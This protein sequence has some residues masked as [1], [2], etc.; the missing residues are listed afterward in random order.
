MS[1][2]VPLLFAA[3]LPAFVVFLGQAGRGDQALWV[4]VSIVPILW[5]A[6]NF[7]SLFQNKQ[8]QREMLGKLMADRTDP[9]I[10]RYFVG[11]AWPKRRMAIHTHEDVGFLL[12]Y[13]ETLEYFGDQQRFVIE[14]SSIRRIG[15]GANMN[16][17]L[18]LGRWILIEA[19]LDSKRTRLQV[20]PRER[21]T[22]FGNLI[23]GNRMAAE[24]RGWVVSGR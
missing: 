4:W 23:L 8:M 9:P 2:L 6:I 5:L 13:P 18:G 12:V 10:R 1:N 14:R 3:P 22:M 24:L 15:F 17:A 19:E 16:T 7:C 21:G 20:E 11:F